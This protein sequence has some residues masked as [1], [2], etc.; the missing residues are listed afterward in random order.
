MAEFVEFLVMEKKGKGNW[1]GY[2]SIKYRVAPRVGEHINL[3]DD[4]GKA[5]VY[6]VVAII[7]P[8]EP[9]S[10]AGDLIVRYITDDTSFRVSL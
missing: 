6:E 8:H 9:A 7:H 2:G 4:E 3:I 10:C 1:K 5:Q